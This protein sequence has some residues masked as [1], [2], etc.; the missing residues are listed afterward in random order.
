MANPSQVEVGQG[1]ATGATA[2]SAVPPSTTF[3]PEAPTGS[4]AGAPGSLGAG[5]KDTAKTATDAI[6]QQ[7][8]QFAGEV[9][10]ELGKTGESQKA[11]GVDALKRFARAIDSAARELEPQSAVV[12]GAVHEAARKVDGLSDNLSNR[13]VNELIESAAQLARAQPVLFL[14]G[15]V[16]A[17]FALARFLKSSSRQGSRTGA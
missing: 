15:S 3:A 9:G 4:S 11:R 12:A 8:A 7:A 5:F 2:S 13:D 17:G 6:R 16:A 1:G 10:R 14:G